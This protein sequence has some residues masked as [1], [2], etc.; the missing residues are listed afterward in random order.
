[1]A[2]NRQIT[3]KDIARITRVSPA[4][5]SMALN[6]KPGVSDEV[7]YEILRVARDLHY[8]PNLVARSLVN[9][10]S[11]SVALMISHT[12]NPIFPEI[13]AAVEEVLRASGYSLTIVSTYDDVDLE[14][15]E[16]G[17]IRARG[18][19]GIITSSV[20]L[21]SA[22]LRQLAREGFPVV[23]VL[24]RMFGPDVVDHVVVD[25][26]KGSSQAVEHLVRLGHRRIGVIA[27]PAS[28]STG[29]ERLAGAVQ[30]L[31]AHRLALPAG[32]RF[33]GDF[34]RKD[35][36]LATHA[37]LK[38]PPRE[39][40]TAIFAA[41]DDMAMGA[42]EAIL[43]SGARVPEDVAVVGFNNVAATSWKTYQITTVDQRADEMG[44]RAAE[45]V[46]QLIERRP[47]YEI[48]CHVVLDPRLIVRRSC[49][50]SAE[51]ARTAGAR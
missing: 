22:H 11:R 2:I 3:I 21:R 28:T 32:L 29:V 40:P 18:I 44:R 17:G 1:M 7:R 12:K 41:N 24:R 13:A 50:A 19:D 20:L 34:S 33:R 49:G 51:E 25:G 8:T 45:R 5:V 39:R 31:K 4:T 15:K 14:V 43:D 9:R 30:A 10:R 6:G 47:G 27:G 16:I 35:G 38:R 42:F 26:V 48:P 46:I 36:Y 37:F 23:A